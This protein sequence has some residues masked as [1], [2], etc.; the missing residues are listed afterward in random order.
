[1]AIELKLEDD[2]AEFR[3]ETRQG[4]FEVNALEL[5]SAM[6]ALGADEKK[7]ADTKQM[8]DAIRQVGR[9]KGNGW[10]KDPK[11][12]TDAELFARGVAINQAYD[13][14]GNEQKPLPTSPTSTA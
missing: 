3:V 6:L 12:I 9:D 10:L 4:W 14:A 5:G 8:A 7:G 2:P 11:K 1:M 13:S